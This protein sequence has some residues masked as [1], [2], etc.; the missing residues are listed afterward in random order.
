MTAPGARFLFFKA[1]SSFAD[2]A[3]AGAVCAAPERR[4][5]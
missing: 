4:N 1:D 2:P 3:A 5:I